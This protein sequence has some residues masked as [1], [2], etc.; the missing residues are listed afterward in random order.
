MGIY[1]VINISWVAR[2]R[3]QVERQKI[4]EVEVDK[5][6]KWKVNKILNQR[7]IRR[8]VKYLVQWKR[9][10]VEYNI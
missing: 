6:K 7:K 2:Y 9:F 8:V 10:I 4:K 1:L 3:E 5:V